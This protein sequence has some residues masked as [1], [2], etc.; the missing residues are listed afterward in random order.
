MSSDLIK[1]PESEMPPASRRSAMR[2]EGI[3]VRAHLTATSQCDLN[4][5]VDGPAEGN[6]RSFQFTARDDRRLPVNH[7]HLH[8]QQQYPGHRPHDQ[9]PRL[10]V[11][12]MRQT[13]VTPTAPA[14]LKQHK[15][16]AGTTVATLLPHCTVETILS[17]DQVIAVSDVA[18]SLKEL[19]LLA[20]GA[21]D[22]DEECMGRLEGALGRDQGLTGLVDFFSAEFEIG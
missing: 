19:V 12:P 16:V 11:S 13:H 17:K 4:S 3:A 15:P 2:I 18:G 22:G 5:Q 21:K 10:Q 8:Q 14:P 9:H 7:H 1:D 6:P 20:L